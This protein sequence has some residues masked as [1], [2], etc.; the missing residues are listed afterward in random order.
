MYVEI[1]KI[2]MFQP[3]RVKS[4]LWR[5]GSAEKNKGKGNTKEERKIMEEG[6]SEEREEM[7]RRTG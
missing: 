7:K 5:E 6:E 1:E 4:Q 2:I 3:T